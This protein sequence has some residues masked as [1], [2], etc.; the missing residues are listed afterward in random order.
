MDPQGKLVLILS[1]TSLLQ[2]SCGESRRA[3]TEECRVFEMN[4]QGFPSD[5]YC[6][7][8]PTEFIPE[9]LSRLGMDHCLQAWDKLTSPEQAR[10]IQSRGL[11]VDQVCNFRIPVR[12][13][14]SEQG[15]AMSMGKRA[16]FS[17]VNAADLQLIEGVG[18][19][20][21]SR[22]INWRSLLSNPVCSIED[23][24]EVRGIGPKAMKKLRAGLQASCNPAE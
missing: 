20:L 7:E 14:I 2:W 5:W 21:S 3:V 1:L 15:V 24:E 11:S 17:Q 13:G 19:A 9:G 16:E 23:L 12:G 8:E 18:P 10:L 4:H 6:L 22:I